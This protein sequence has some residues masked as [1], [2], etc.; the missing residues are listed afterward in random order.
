MAGMSAQV[1]GNLRGLAPSDLKSV[2]RLLRRR[3]AKN[4]IVG[5]E[6]ARELYAVASKLGRKVGVLIDREGNI[7][8]V[9]VGTKVLLYLP[10][11]GRFGLARGRLRRLR[12]I[13]AEIATKGELALTQ[14]IYTDLEKLRLDLV[15]VVRVETSLVRMVY[16]YNIPYREEQP[17]VVAASVATERVKDLLSLIHI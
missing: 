15:A 7:V 13:Y 6:F 14:D 10:E 2:Q 5:V 17:G 4:E 12:L 8:E 3:I 1:S 16:A 11:L 9:I